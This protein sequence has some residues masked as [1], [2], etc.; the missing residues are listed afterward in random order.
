MDL[1]QQLAYLVQKTDFSTSVSLIPMEIPLIQK[2][3]MIMQKS[4]N[5]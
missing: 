4:L 5:V 2:V 3:T 1:I